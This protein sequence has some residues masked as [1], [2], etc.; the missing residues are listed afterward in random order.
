MSSWLER[1]LARCGV[2]TCREAS[3]LADEDLRG[4]LPLRLRL[5]VTVCPPCRRFRRQMDLV[6]R[7]LASVPPEPLAVTDREKL[8]VGLRERFKAAK[9]VRGP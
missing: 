4:A 8:L 7:T 3:E 6:G 5:H 9:D 1:V 2:G